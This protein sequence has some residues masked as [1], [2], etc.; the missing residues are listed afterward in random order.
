MAEPGP[1][2]VVDPGSV[3]EVQLGLVFEQ[4]GE[5]LLLLQVPLVD[6]LFCLLLLEVGDSL[7][8]R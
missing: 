6:G 7:H 1:D 4:L 8:S 3:L 2:Q 5:I